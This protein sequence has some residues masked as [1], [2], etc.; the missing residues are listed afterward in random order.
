M[1]LQQGNNL[2]QRKLPNRNIL[3]RQNNDKWALLVPDTYY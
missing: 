3:E 1:I 2:Q